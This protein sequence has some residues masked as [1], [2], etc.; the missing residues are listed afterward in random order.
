MVGFDLHIHSTASDGATAPADLVVLAKEQDLLGIA[1]TDHDTTYGIAEAAQKAAELDV[2]LIAGIELSAEQNDKDVHILGYWLDTEKIEADPELREMHQSR[3]QRCREI[4]SRLS[5]LGIELDA[6]QIIAKAGE[7]G[8]PG[9][10]HIAM[11]LVEAGYCGSIKDAFNKWLGRGM[12]GYVARHKLEPLQ[13]IQII[14]RAQGVPVLAHPGLGVPD[15]IIPRLAKAGLGGIEVYHPDHNPMAERRYL[16]LAHKFRLAATG[17]SD[18][19]VQ[20]IRSIG[21]RVTTVR[22]MARLAAKREE[23]L[24]RGGSQ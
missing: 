20:G 22:Q 24:G 21:C 17:G 12:P 5:R 14:L 1:I 9:R 11:A 13:A 8:T 2:P 7:H 19:H 4:V 18:F 10:P 16:Q 3:F 23:L 15:G 6:E